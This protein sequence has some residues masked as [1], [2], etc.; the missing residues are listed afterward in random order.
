MLR[1][2][3]KESQVKKA[4]IQKSLQVLGLVEE[5]D[6]WSTALDELSTNFAQKSD[7]FNAKHTKV[8]E[9]LSQE[10]HLIGST[11]HDASRVT[12]LK[13]LDQQHTDT[14]LSIKNASEAVA[15]HKKEVEELLSGQEYDALIRIEKEQQKLNTAKNN[16]LKNVQSAVQ[17]YAAYLRKQKLL[18]PYDIR[19]FN[20]LFIG[21][22]SIDQSGN[23]TFDPSINQPD[24]WNVVKTLFEQIDARVKEAREKYSRITRSVS[25]PNPDI[26]LQII[27]H[28][29]AEFRSIDK[30]AQKPSEQLEQKKQLMME[31]FSVIGQLSEQYANTTNELASYK[32][33]VDEIQ[34]LS[35][36]AVEA[37]RLDK[38][39]KEQKEVDELRA[40]ALAKAS[41]IEKV[42]KRI[43]E[44]MAFAERA[45]V[46]D[47][48][49]VTQCLGII[50]KSFHT[51]KPTTAAED[52]QFMKEA[53]TEIGK[54]AQTVKELAQIHVE[55]TKK[56][57]ES[58]ALFE[59]YDTEE[60]WNAYMAR[61]NEVKV[62]AAPKLTVTIDIPPSPRAESVVDIGES[63]SSVG[64]A[65]TPQSLALE[66]PIATPIAEENAPIDSAVFCKQAYEPCC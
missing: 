58:K 57:A 65:S 63:P 44:Q 25:T 17:A 66:S 35:D 37:Y 33:S 30:I 15:A 46:H 22:A 43:H 50:K 1:Q 52:I 59:N 49:M 61:K 24:S 60:H 40:A 8:T 53:V 42:A 14:K 16:L 12:T 29:Q 5:Y 62:E 54:A 19:E 27:S 32:K 9:C 55:V 7:A 20:A 18:T 56:L 6:A 26:A 39:E 23:V 36:H 10:E 47:Y 28:L 64:S 4:N 3:E 51:T 2:R 38:L 34:L 41:L 21:F 48:R 31:N 11:F 13:A 45:S